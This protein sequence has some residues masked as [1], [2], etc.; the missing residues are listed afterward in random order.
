RGVSLGRGALRH[1]WILR[2]LE[3]WE[4]TGDPGPSATYAER[5]TFMVRHFHLLVKDR[6]ER[7]GCLSFRKVANWYCRVLRPGRDVQQRLI[8]LEHVQEFDEIVEGLRTASTHRS[9]EEWR[10][11]DVVIAVPKGPIEHW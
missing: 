1:P 8:R 4:R 7:F 9:G 11:E 10:A 6:G 2:Q 5:L 3:R